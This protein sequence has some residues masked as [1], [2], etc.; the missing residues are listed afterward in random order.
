MIR[1]NIFRELEDIIKIDLFL[2]AFAV[3]EVFPWLSAQTSEILKGSA[4]CPV[5]SNKASLL[6][7]K[8][9]THLLFCRKVNCL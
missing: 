5:L 9:P 2:T 4:S 6:V 1:H 3:S 7:D 8:D